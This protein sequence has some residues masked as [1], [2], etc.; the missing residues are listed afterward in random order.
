MIVRTINGEE[1]VIAEKNLPQ[2]QT[3]WNATEGIS[4]ILNKPDTF[5]PSEHTHPAVQLPDLHPLALS[6]AWSDI[7]GKPSVF[8]PEDHEHESEDLHLHDIAT[9]GSWN[10][11]EDVPDTFPPEEHEHEVEEFP[12]LHV[13]ASTGDYNDLENIPTEFPPEAHEHESEDLNL[14]VIAETGSWND[15]EDRPDVFPPED[16]EHEQDELPFLHR[17][18]STGEYADL[19]NIPDVFPPTPHEHESVDL[20]LHR[21]ATTGQWSDI[22]GKPSTFP[23]TDHTHPAAQ[24]PELHPV[25]IS[26]DYNDLINR[27]HTH[28]MS[29][30]TQLESIIAALK[31]RASMLEKRTT[32]LENLG[33]FIKSYE[34]IS[35][36]PT[37]I[38]QISTSTSV[39]TVNDFV[40]VRK[41]GD[42]SS[43]ANF[44]LKSIDSDTGLLT[45]EFDVKFDTDITGKQEVLSNGRMITIDDNVVNHTQMTPQSGGPA[46]D[47]SLQFGQTFIVPQVVS[48]DTGHTSSIV[49]RTLTLPTLQEA[50]GQIQSDW[51]EDDPNSPSFIRNKQIFVDDIED[52]KEK[53]L[54]A[55]EDIEIILDANITAI[56]HI[57]DGGT[58]SAT[59]GFTPGTQTPVYRIGKVVFALYT[60]FYNGAFTNTLLGTLPE[61][62]RP[63]ET[64]T[65]ISCTFA[66][67]SET[68]SRILTIHP[69]GR[70]LLNSTIASSRMWVVSWSAMFETPENSGGLRGI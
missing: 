20:N 13:V 48:N 34:T 67:Q 10:D 26:G 25:A 60:R 58:T 56:Q 22:E 63:V 44:V 55:I 7:I 17:V 57:E 16:H 4:S 51:L 33:V 15:L 6:G 65:G 69:D 14:H 46:S 66:S 42:P 1:K 36:L 53:T 2:I 47:A 19:E 59:A 39:P 68:Q 70:I 32:S 8:P 23:A 21:V 28:L 41:Y 18:A 64:V 27:E 54:E 31:D 11:L 45:W 9:S 37:N 61:H 49:N 50:A 5:P 40:T 30:I 35:D 12:F 52:F 38:S 3:D 29:E 62:F 24:L 43:A